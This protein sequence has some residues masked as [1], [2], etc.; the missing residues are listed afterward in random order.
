M[1][2]PAD[3]AGP[4]DPVGL[5]DVGLL[6]P[7]AAGT[8][9]E[10]LTGDAAVVSAMV[11]AE[12]ALLDA[13]VG[14]GLA[15]P[16]AKGLVDDAQVDARAL[17]LD[18]VEGGNP[19]IPLVAA[20]RAGRGP[21]LARW[22]HHG[23][24]SQD[25]VDTALMLVSQ[26]VLAQI[27][28]YL[29]SVAQSLSTLVRDR[30]AT[31]MVARTLTQQALPTTLGMRASGW[32]ACVHDA[33]RAVRSCLPLPASLGGPAGT[34]SDYGRQGSAVV[35][36]Y[37]NALGLRAPVGPWHTRRTPVLGVSCALVTTGAACGKVAADVLVMSQ[38]EV[39]EVREG[40]GGPSSSMAHKANPVQSVLVAS[41]ARQLPA[42]GAVLGGSAVAEQERPAGAWHAEWQPLRTMLR[43]AG[44]A[45]SRTSHLVAG[46][47]F[48]DD[49]MARNLG[50]LVGALE[51]DSAW[52]DR[53]LASVD[54]WTDR[55]LAEHEELF[56]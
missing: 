49:A 6:S 44:G 17:A 7:V 29:T 11:R 1:S 13:L 2:S 42:L 23:A 47:R 39:G 43:L 56:G 4:A 34:L 55:V 15:P 30:R 8:S 32:L 12:R 37:A 54:V 25:V 50:R 46:L 5:A 35:A 48:D 51:E 18:A 27:L 24:T 52:V 53:Q 45:A 41:A 16:E 21:D 28:V 22:L 26:D 20:L 36:A 10:A 33:V 31:P 38:S 14:T 9:V 19:V 40:T 3:V